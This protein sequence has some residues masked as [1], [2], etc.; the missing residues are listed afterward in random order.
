MTVPFPD[1][2]A[3]HQELSR[4]IDSAIARILASGRYVQGEDVRRNNN[5][6]AGLL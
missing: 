5:L 4:E 3:A 6:V 2:G 1:L